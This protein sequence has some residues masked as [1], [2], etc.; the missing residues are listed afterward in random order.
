M[1]STSSVNPKSALKCKV[2]DI[3]GL[4][5]NQPGR[6]LVVCVD[7]KS[8][9]QAPDRTQPMI[10]GMPERRIHDYNRHGITTLFSP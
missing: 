6:T 2:R 1:L 4:C 7:K 5:L 3:T 8:Q 9:I 10:P